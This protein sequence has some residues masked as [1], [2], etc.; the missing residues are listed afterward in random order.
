MSIDHQTRRQFAKLTSAGLSGISLSSLINSA[1][2]ESSIPKLHHPPKAKSVIFLYMSGGISHV[3]TFDPKPL[4]KKLHGQP[5][6]VALERT[7][8][9]A[10]GNIQASPWESKPRGQSG[11][12]ITDMLPKIAARADDLAIVRSMTA[13]FSEHA[14]GNFFMHSGFPFLGHPSAGAWV[15]YALGSEKKTFPASSFF[16][17]KTP[18]S[19]TVA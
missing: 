16:N 9:D 5:M 7:Q 11:I 18:P 13:K 14:Q 15:N 4:L 3:D 19:P 8:F 2:G 10:N 6:P 1:A 17:R 12:E